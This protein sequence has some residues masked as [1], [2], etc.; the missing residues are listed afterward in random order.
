MVATGPI[1]V[2]CHNQLIGHLPTCS[3]GLVG[4]R[5]HTLDLAAD[6]HLVGAKQS[7]PT[8]VCPRTQK[9][10]QRIGVDTRPSCSILEQ[11][12]DDGPLVWWGRYNSRF[13]LL[14]SSLLVIVDRPLPMPWL[15]N[16]G[17]T[18]A[19]SVRKQG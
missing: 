17:S 19:V 18:L 16:Q 6:N 10:Q 11:L 14:P 2:D 9:L 1:E 15:N 13:F 5:T 7:H 12:D 4:R 8:M 3:I